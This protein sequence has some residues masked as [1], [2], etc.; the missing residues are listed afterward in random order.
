M[1]LTLDRMCVT[2]GKLCVRCQTLYDNGD[3]DKIDVDLG[4]AFL[5]VAKTQRFLSDITIYKIV[6][7][8]NRVYIVVKKGEAAKLYRAGDK[9]LTQ[10]KS[11][12]NW[13]IFM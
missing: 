7:T 11:G 9:L 6:E 5:N 4:K 10:L 3:I 2:S 12:F 8:A 1:K 13:V